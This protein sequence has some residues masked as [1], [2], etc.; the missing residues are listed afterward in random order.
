MLDKLISGSL[1][2]KESLVS[3][4][5]DVIEEEQLVLFVFLM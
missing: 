3:T 5:E 4:E 2:L 1:F